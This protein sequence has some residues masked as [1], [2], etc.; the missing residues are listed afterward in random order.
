[1]GTG[2]DVLPEQ[3]RGNCLFLDGGGLGVA[4]LLYC[5]EQLGGEAEISE[6]HAFGY[7]FS[8]PAS[9]GGAAVRHLKHWMIP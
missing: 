9:P 6:L 3:D 4:L 2:L 7:S 1:L 8:V 5:A